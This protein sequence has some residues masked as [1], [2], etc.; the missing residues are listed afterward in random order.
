MVM[1]RSKARSI[2]C[3]LVDWEWLVNLKYLNLPEAALHHNIRHMICRMENSKS[4]D[5][6]TP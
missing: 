6:V 2:R 4:R 5:A 3:N 1:E